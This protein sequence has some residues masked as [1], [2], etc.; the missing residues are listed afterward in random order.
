MVLAQTTDALLTLVTPDKLFVAGTVMWGATLAYLKDPLLLYITVM[1]ITI[2]SFPEW[3][4]TMSLFMIYGIFNIAT[5]YEPVT[6][7]GAGFVSSVA[8]GIA[9]TLEGTFWVVLI[10]WALRPFYEALF[11]F[12]FGN[13]F[14]ELEYAI[15]LMVLMALKWILENNMLDTFG[16]QIEHVIAQTRDYFRQF[17]GFVKDNLR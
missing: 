17:K 11:S 5:R 13:A 1:T 6:G 2:L 12:Q 16:D 8:D 3:P 4:L 10:F 7:T 15:P 14:S 9:A